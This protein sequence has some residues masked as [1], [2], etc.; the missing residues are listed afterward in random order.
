MCCGQNNTQCCSNHQGTYAFNGVSINATSHSASNKL[1][2]GSIAGIVIG[3]IALIVLIALA[4][5]LAIKIR[6]D[7]R[8]RRLEGRD[9]YQ[10]DVMERK[11]PPESTVRPINFHASVR[12]QQDAA[13]ST[14]P[15]YPSQAHELGDAN[16]VKRF[17][18]PG[19]D[20]YLREEK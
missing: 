2:G 19:S 14:V 5:L 12:N 17:E 1:S 15:R 4:I 3:V 7:R 6:D 8:Q 20:K 16:S 9:Q 13:V 10:Q 11:A 18:A